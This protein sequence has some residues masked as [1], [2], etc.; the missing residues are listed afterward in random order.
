MPSVRPGTNANQRRSQRILLS[1]GIIVT[2]KRTNGTAFSER[3]KTEVVGAH[4]AQILL[5]E[6]VLP[7]QILTMTNILTNEEIAC[8]VIDLN[9][10][11]AA[12]PEV[13][14]EFAHPCPRFWRV[15]FPPSD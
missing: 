4:G 9:H 3:T 14:V 7:G 12:A 10:G 8:T 5:R 2:G 11:Q 1:L 6:P 13:G 15:S